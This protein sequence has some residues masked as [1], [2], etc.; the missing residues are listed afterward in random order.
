MVEFIIANEQG[1]YL[2]YDK[3]KKLCLTD[4]IEK[5]KR[6]STKAKAY[7]V[8]TCSFPKKRREGWTVIE[9]G[10]ADVEEKVDKTQE[11]NVPILIDSQSVSVQICDGVER[12]RADIDSNK[13]DELDW[14][15]IKECIEKI[16]IDVTKYRDKIYEQLAQI[17][18][19]LCD[20]DH[21]CEFFKYNAAQGYK[22]YS[23]MRMRRIKRRYLKN[24]YKK[25]MA[26]LN[27]SYQNITDGVLTKVFKEID[28]QTYE[29]RAL[30][31]LFKV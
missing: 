20:C 5:A 16:Y 12:Y 13:T 22:L 17:E 25:A 23:M 14:D 3:L 1:M 30:K 19:E 11:V 21:A 28:E 26:I 10:T 4:K 2:F 6:F 9:I 15:A 29:P 7:N 24:E 31:E 18:A 8:L 27:M